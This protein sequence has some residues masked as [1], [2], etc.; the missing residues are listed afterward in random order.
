MSRLKA[1]MRVM[2]GAPVLALAVA[3]GGLALLAGCQRQPP[4]PAPA[5]AAAGTT[6]ARDAEPRP[7]AAPAA[8]AA[9]AAASVPGMTVA[10]APAAA[11]AAALVAASAGWPKVT[12]HWLRGDTDS[13]F[14]AWF[15]HGELRYLD[16][17][18]V[19]R[20]AAP[21][22]G[23][24]YYERGALFYYS[25]E[26]PAGAQVGGGATAM[27]ETVPVLAEFDGAQPRRAVRIEHYGE[28]PLAAAAVT[29]LERQAAI[30]AGVARDEWSAA[31]PR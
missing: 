7:G 18:A 13:R 20:A 28:V 4:P 29:A 12:G 19:R 1:P 17:L 6:G 9:E 15:E 2:A 10:A 25:G 5:P 8:P 23:R 16:E 27:A 22:H 26:A 11:R 21:L 24:Y 31:G 3:S 30:L 14:T